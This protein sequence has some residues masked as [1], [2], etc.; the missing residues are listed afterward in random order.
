MLASR[1]QIVH[2]VLNNS[3]YSIGASLG[4]LKSISY[5]EQ[6]LLF[7]F[8]EGELRLELNIAEILHF[9]ESYKKNKR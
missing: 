8:E 5:S 9:V 4:N 3:G 1:S 2:E 6:I 7:Q